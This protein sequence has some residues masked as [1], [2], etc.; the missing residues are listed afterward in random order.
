M[1]LNLNPPKKTVPHKRKAKT[2]ST[3]RKRPLVTS[4][5]Q[6][7]PSSGSGPDEEPGPSGDR[8]PT[9]PEEEDADEDEE[10]EEDE[11]SAL[12][13]YDEP[14]F[15]HLGRIAGR[16][17]DNWDN[18]TVIINTGV[19]GLIRKADAPT[20]TLEKYR[21][22]AA[23]RLFK[24]V[25]GLLDVLTELE[26]MDDVDSDA[27][28]MIGAALDVGRKQT[29]TEDRGTVNNDAVDW[30]DHFKL[31]ASKGD[32]GFKNEGCGR[33]LCPA[34]LD[35]DDPSVREQLVRDGSLHN[36]YPRFLWPSGPDG[37]NVGNY[38]SGFCRGELLVKAVTAILLS[39]SSARGKGKST[40]KGNAELYDVEYIDFPI[41]A[42]V[43]M[44]LQFAL[45]TQANFSAGPGQL[46]EAITDKFRA[47]AR[48]EWPY[49]LFYYQ[50]MHDLEVT[51][52][53]EDR[54]ALLK[55]W[56]E[57]IFPQVNGQD[58]AA[59]PEDEN[60]MRA[61]M[62]AQAE[63]R[64]RARAGSEPTEPEAAEATT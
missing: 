51:M 42:D 24:V 14:Y 23:E 37:F 26:G 9:P 35:W 3:P 12:A 1:P 2:N 41:I 45:H 43:A 6:P 36:R 48:N 47:K 60:E 4:Q 62:T 50:I 10:D 61:I 40:R 49:R 18:F 29:R 64:R 38:W 25:P 56:N 58:L 20:T 28:N 44:L 30:I 16:M 17:V 59:Q 31:P 15:Q 54:A 22:R 27:T 11:E 7:G 53:E 46:G 8:Q 19:I 57:L 5:Q 33:Y 13:Q 34:N 63:E 39:R 21:L 55:W 52:D 32:R